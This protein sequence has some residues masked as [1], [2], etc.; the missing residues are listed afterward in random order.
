MGTCDLCKPTNINHVI[1][2]TCVCRGLELK[3]LNLKR[4]QPK[5]GEQQLERGN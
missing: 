4:N 3:T 2:I 5:K 1:I